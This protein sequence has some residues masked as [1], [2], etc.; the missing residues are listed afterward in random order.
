MSNSATRATCLVGGAGCASALLLFAGA[1]LYPAL[2]AGETAEA[3]PNFAPNINTSWVLDRTVDDL[4]PPS[5]GPGP[6]SFDK[7]HPYVPNG[8]GPHPTYRV[9]DISNPI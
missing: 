7:A 3:V 9:A 4:L 6:M 2:A 5:S 1:A 8:R